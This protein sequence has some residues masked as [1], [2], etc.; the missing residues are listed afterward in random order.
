[1][2]DVE[3]AWKRALVTRMWSSGGLCASVL[4]ETAEPVTDRYCPGTRADLASFRGE[5]GGSR[6]LI[7]KEREGVRECCSL[8]LTERASL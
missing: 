7:G 6:K 4:T 5:T 2:W 1:M 8:F 3:K